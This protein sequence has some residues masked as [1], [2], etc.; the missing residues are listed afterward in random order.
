M[1]TPPPNLA[2]HNL[3]LTQTTTLSTSF[4]DQQSKP[5]TSVELTFAEYDSEM[6]LDLDLND[7]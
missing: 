4:N 3:Q 1:F 2:E 7:P 5:S 6:E